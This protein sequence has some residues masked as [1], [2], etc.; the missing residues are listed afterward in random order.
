[1]QEKEDVPAEGYGEEVE[2]PEQDMYDDIQGVVDPPEPEQDMYDDVQGAQDPPEP[3]Q[4]MYDDVQG[5]DE[6]EQSL[7]DDATGGS[8]S[9]SEQRSSVVWK[10]YIMCLVMLYPGGTHCSNAL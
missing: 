1:M 3:E 9:S 8:V 5:A 4:D 10:L 6:P 2:E 7:Y